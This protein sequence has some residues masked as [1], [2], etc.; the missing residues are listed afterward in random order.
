VIDGLAVWVGFRSGRG[1]VCA[2]TG[3]R[4]ALLFLAWFGRFD[5]ACFVVG[6]GMELSV[7]ESAKNKD[8]YGSVLVAV[9]CTK[10]AVRYARS[11]N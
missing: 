1:C 4:V 7:Q 8:P 9:L 11:C 2:G 3:F 5:L 6:Y 10:A